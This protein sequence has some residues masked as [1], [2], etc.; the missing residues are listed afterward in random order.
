M[1]SLVKIAS[2]NSEPT[3]AVRSNQKGIK[4]DRPFIGSYNSHIC[5]MDNGH[6]ALGL[7]VVRQWVL[8]WGI[9]F[10]KRLGDNSLC[11]SVWVEER[12]FLRLLLF[13]LGS[14]LGGMLGYFYWFEATN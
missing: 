10:S 3:V 13:F 8:R 2:Q 11:Q 14:M 7:R 4:T 5:N 9:I 6:M 12:R 1:T